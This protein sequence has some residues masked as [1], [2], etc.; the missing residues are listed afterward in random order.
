MPELNSRK[1]TFYGLA[2]YEL[3]KWLAC[4]KKKKDRYYNRGT[5]KAQ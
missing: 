2:W 5:K 3:D 4:K 1:N